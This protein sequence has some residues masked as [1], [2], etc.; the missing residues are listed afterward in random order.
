MKRYRTRFLGVLTGLLLSANVVA[1][2]ASTSTM[3][4]ITFVDPAN[5]SLMELPNGSRQPVQVGMSI[6][7]N[8]KIIA[9]GEGVIRGEYPEANCTVELHP[10]TVY[11][12]LQ[13][14]V[15]N[16]AS[17]ERGKSIVR[18]SVKTMTMPATSSGVNVANAGGVNPWLIAGGA[19]AAVG[20]VA[21]LEDDDDGD[22]SDQPVSP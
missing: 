20:V 7:T 22:S 9:A 14:G 19:V 5:K 18:K 21:L 4:N 3:L 10:N 17:V 16:P 6:P 11:R 13:A 12:V 2:G 15:C 1:Q 8:A